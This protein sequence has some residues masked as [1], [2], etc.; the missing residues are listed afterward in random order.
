M[1]KQR[2]TEVGNFFFTLEEKKKKNPL[3]TSWQIRG[4]WVKKKKKKVHKQFPSCLS[5]KS[6]FLTFHILEMS[7]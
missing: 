2:G 7:E 5:G 1:E 6:W 4:V 3:Q